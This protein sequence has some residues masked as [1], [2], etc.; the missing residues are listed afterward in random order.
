M[1]VVKGVDKV[2]ET[3]NWTIRNI[4]TDVIEKLKDQAAK[5]HRSLNSE[6]V[7]ILER[8]VK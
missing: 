6:V 4:P 5:N 3:K 1:C 8:E 2:K 7:S